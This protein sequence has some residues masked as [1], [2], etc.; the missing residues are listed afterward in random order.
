MWL[1]VTIKRYNDEYKEYKNGLFLIISLLREFIWLPP[2]QLSIKWIVRAGQQLICRNWKQEALT[3]TDQP[4]WP[5]YPTHSRTWA[6]VQ[7]KDRNFKLFFFLILHFLPQTIYP[8]LH[9][10]SCCRCVISLLHFPVQVITAQEPSL[11]ATSHFPPLSIKHREDDF[12]T[13]QPNG[14]HTIP[15]SDL[16]LYW[17]FSLWS[18]FCQGWR[19]FTFFIFASENLLLSFNSLILYSL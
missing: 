18:Y 7:E 5:L 2:K 19:E 14:P 10:H 13:L 4:L 1:F 6:M 12:H 11:L 17:L 8:S 16:M 15:M 9:I 3:F